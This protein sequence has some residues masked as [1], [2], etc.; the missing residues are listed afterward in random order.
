[1]RKAAPGRLL[2][3]Q[4]L[5]N[6]LDV[7]KHSDA[8]ATP[9]AT[10]A[11]LAAKGLVPVGTKITAS[12]R[13]RVI[14]VREALRALCLANNGEPID[15]DA[16]APLNQAAARAT[17]RVDVGVDGGTRLAPARAGVDGAIAQ[18]LAIVHD[19]VLDDTWPRLKACAAETCQ[20]AFYDASRNC[21][22]AWCVMEVCGNRAKARSFRARHG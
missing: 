7:E 22:G 11:W 3:V 6:T 4:K 20:W 12:D 2:L 8:L 21:S 1:M 18:L 5:I 9:A 19:A 17:L 13:K 14:A 15:D 16:V 10:A